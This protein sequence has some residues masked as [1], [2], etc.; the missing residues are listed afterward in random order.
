MQ[1]GTLTRDEIT[2]SQYLDYAGA[3]NMAVLKLA[4]VDAN[5][6]GANG[7]N[8]DLAIRNHNLDD[9]KAVSVAQY[10]KLA[11]IPFTFE[12]RRSSCI[13]RGAT[14][15]NLLICKG[16]FDEVLGLCTSVRQGGVAVPLDA[17]KQ[18]FLLEL[19]DALNK[20]GYRVLLAAE[21]QLFGIDEASED[22]LEG[23]ETCMTLEG[24]LS[25]ID[26]PKEDAR[27]SISQLKALGVRVKVLTGDNLPVA[28]NV[29]QT[30]GLLSANDETD[31]DVQ[32]V[33]GPQLAQIEDT[34]EFD[35]VV[36]TCT[37]FAKLTPLQKAL[38]VGSLRRAGNCVGM[39]GDGINDC[40]ALRRADVGISVDSGTSVAK[41]C[42]DLIL[43]EK[44]L[45]L[46]VD[47]VKTGR[48]THGNTIK[49]I[50]VG[51]AEWTSSADRLLMCVA[52][53]GIVQ[54][55]QRVQRLGRECLAALSTSKSDVD[56][57]EGSRLI[58]TDAGSAA[59]GTEPALRYQP[60]CDSVGWRRRRV[61]ADAQDVEHAGPATLRPRAGPHKL[62]N[63]HLDVCAGLVLLRRANG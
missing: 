59:A 51:L 16:A 50:K 46:I 40:M 49:Y 21:K 58:V 53:G 19:S 25:F 52:D 17:E 12:R 4:T 57:M 31:D 27:E 6:Q 33:T 39:L 13:V 37:V 20:K 47:S 55:W 38:V 32:A 35:A 44:G 26:P 11:A 60:D 41:G 22:G 42:A 28:L 30:L 15:Q 10:E 63:R 48:I 56:L 54:L 45:G 8:I 24:M 23:L 5:V 7:N 18:S 29:C 1:T 9:G 62:R 14:G 43:A 61:R 34:P 2:L 3:E 36:M